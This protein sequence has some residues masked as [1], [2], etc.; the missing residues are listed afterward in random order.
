MY[1]GCVIE[2]KIG[3]LTKYHLISI[4]NRLRI[5]CPWCH[6]KGFTFKKA[7]DLKQHI[8]ANHKSILKEAPADCFVE[9]SC[10]LVVMISQRLYKSH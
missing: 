9:P 5:L 3:R 1:N 2:E 8:K 10:F 7:V 4:H 6:Q